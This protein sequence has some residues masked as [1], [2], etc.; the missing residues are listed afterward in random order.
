VSDIEFDRLLAA[1]FGNIARVLAP[2]RAFY[3]WGG[4]PN[5][6]NY[7]PVL[8]VYAKRPASST[9]RLAPDCTETAKSARS[10][11]GS[12]KRKNLR[13]NRRCSRVVAFNCI[14]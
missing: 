7:P 8:K 14:A 1:W 5:C 4:Y 3:V 10:E 11:A 13:Q 6:A 9:L 2:G 12:T